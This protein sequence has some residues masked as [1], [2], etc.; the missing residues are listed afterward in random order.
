L[1]CLI[2]WLTII[3]EMLFKKAGNTKTEDNYIPDNAISLTNAI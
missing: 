1:P 2:V 3:S